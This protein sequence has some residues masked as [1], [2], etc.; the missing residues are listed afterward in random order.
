MHLRWMH[1]SCGCWRA[2]SVRPYAD[3][4]VVCIWTSVHGLST[5][6]A[7][8]AICGATEA[9]VGR[10]SVQQGGSAGV[11]GRSH[12][13][14]HTAHRH[15]RVRGGHQAVRQGAAQRKGGGSGG[16]GRAGQTSPATVGGGRGATPGGA[17]HGGCWTVVVAGRHTHLLPARRPA[18]GAYTP[19]P[20]CI[21]L[22]ASRR[23][24]KC[25]M[26]C[27]SLAL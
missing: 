5:K 17:A 18:G 3:V 1:T 12:R 22:T 11:R 16:S 15:C 8:E 24:T 19:P 21:E 7:S 13:V 25:R 20:L 10:R 27:V 2:F 6:K 4:G 14:Y 9:Y 26:G 23:A